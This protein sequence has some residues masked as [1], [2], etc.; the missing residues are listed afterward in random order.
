MRHIFFLV[1]QTLSIFTIAQLVQSTFLGHNIPAGQQR[2]NHPL[3]TQQPK[4]N[5]SDQ[6]QTNC[7][8]LVD[9]ASIISLSDTG[10]T[11]TKSC[12]PSL[13]SRQL[14][15]C[16]IHQLLDNGM[17]GCYQCAPQLIPAIVNRIFGLSQVLQTPSCIDQFAAVPGCV[18]YNEVRT[19]YRY[20]CAQCQTSSMRLVELVNGALSQ[21]ICAEALDISGGQWSS[22][23]KVRPAMWGESNFKFICV[24]DKAAT[25]VRLLVNP[26]KNDNDSKSLDNNQAT[27][28]SSPDD[29][30]CLFGSSKGILQFDSNCNAPTTGNSWIK[31]ESNNF[32][33]ASSLNFCLSISNINANDKQADIVLGPPSTD[34]TF[35]FGAS[36]KLFCYDRENQIVGCFG[37]KKNAP[38]LLLGDDLDTIDKCTSL[39]TAQNQ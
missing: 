35:R 18:V 32:C 37:I 2:A 9:Q 8:T 13:V 19:L 5:P 7:I 38:I 31:N 23:T 25:S 22:C 26:P 10:P 14:D 24:D 1:I 34:N 4:L 29:I 21:T 12:D 16:N 30:S 17:L 36:G 11:F 15:G 39:T 6:K 27:S 33:L 28:Q 20:Q 3:G